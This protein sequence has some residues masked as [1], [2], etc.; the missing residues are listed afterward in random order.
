MAGYGPNGGVQGACNAAAPFCQSAVVTSKTATGPFTTQ[1]L[2]TAVD[3]LVVAGGA[4][5]GV[6]DKGGGGGGAGGYL[7][8]FGCACRGQVSVCG[9][10]AYTMTVGGGGAGGVDNP[11][12]TGGKGSDGGNTIA[13]CGTP[14]AI[15]AEGGGAGGGTNA[16]PGRTGNSGGSGGGS[17]MSANPCSGGAG[18]T[19]PSNPVQ[20]MAGG[21]GS[22]GGATLG[23][24]GGGA[25]GA[26]SASPNCGTTPSNPSRGT[27]ATTNISA[28]PVA[29]ATGGRFNCWTEPASTPIPAVGN[30]TDNTG[31]GACAQ[32]AANPGCYMPD[33]GTF[34]GVNGA[35]GV[36][37]IRYKFQN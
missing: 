7:T 10:T 37:I 33:P 3:Y 32:N 16:F 31:N 17:G 18:N 30:A 25:T 11:Y 9:A 8:S 22:P 24:S 1:P 2:T 29:Y 20:G 15:T 5:G 27:G 6:C 34:N 12:A 19:P 14:I 4:G 13:F 35:S 26:G 23:G 21:V 36:V 28:S